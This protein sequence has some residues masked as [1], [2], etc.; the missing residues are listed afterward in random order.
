M[1]RTI[2]HAASTSVVVGGMAAGL[3][4]ALASSSLSTEPAA[5][6]LPSIRAPEAKVCGYDPMDWSA[7]RATRCASNAV[8]ST[9]AVTGAVVQG[10]RGIA[11]DVLDDALTSVHAL[12][13]HVE[14]RVSRLVANVDR[15]ADQTV[16]TSLSIVANATS[17][18]VGTTESTIESA[19]SHVSRTVVNTRG[20]VSN[21]ANEAVGTAVSVVG[22]GVTM[23]DDTVDGVPGTLDCVGGITVGDLSLNGAL[24]CS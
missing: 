8:D 17:Q 21:T 9:M 3:V 7:N 12:G 23:A 15:L 5:I 10:T 4:L 11:E 2:A 18:L 13:D 20:A 22:G 16:A 14:S 1:N 19:T 24:G 6:S